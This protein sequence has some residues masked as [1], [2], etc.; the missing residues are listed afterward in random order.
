MAL[1]VTKSS[2]PALVAP[3]KPTPGGDLPLTSTDKSR[4]FLYYTSFHV[5]ERPIHRPAD[6]IRRALSEA[7]V[8][9]YPIAGRVS[10]GDDVRIS[11]TGDGVAFVAATASCTL[12]DVRCLDAPLAVPLDE[13][14]PRYGEARR[15]S[16]PLMAM[17]V[18]EFSCGGYVVGVT[19]N[20]VV[21]DASGLAQFLQAVGERASG[22]PSPSSAV[23]VRHDAS[24][25]DIPQL[26]TALPRSPASFKH[27]DFAY[28][29]RTIPWSYIDRV[30]AE[31]RERAGGLQSCTVFEVVTAAI[32]QCR[33]RAI[34]AAPDAPSPLVFSANVRKL[35]GAK[36]GYYGNCVT[37]QMV[38]ATSGAVADLVRLI[39]DAKER[40]PGT[41][42]GTA[43]LALE[44]EVVDA[45][46]G[47]NALFVS[48]W[49]HIGLD[50]VD[51]GGGKPA[52]VVPNMERTV[53]PM[54]WPC[55]PCSRKK[56]DGSNVVACC[57]TKEHVEEF[58][59][60]LD[61]LR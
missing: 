17:Q 41:L 49:A 35:V 30:K 47:Y 36:D 22:L 44:E 10:A 53:A 42:A 6:T 58:D 7:L 1:S 45:L 26:F 18:T 37:S 54:C 23:P 39:K 46:C 27:V 16:D 12:Q 59:A 11:C 52:R 15:T 50:G 2:S 60:Q 40:L 33:A 56:D 29:D 4:L 57:V 19:T 3:W 31:F 55:L 8:H 5:F 51:F 13:L 28:T 48:S 43:K 34:G 20:H 61:R 25:P 32:W 24:L 9:Y 14:V 21:A 38:T